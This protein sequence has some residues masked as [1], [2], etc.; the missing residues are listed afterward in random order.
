VG[1]RFAI[2]G[3]AL[4]LMTLGAACGGGSSGSPAPATAGDFVSAFQQAFCEL[5]VRCKEE[6]DQATCM[7]AEPVPTP[8][9]AMLVADVGN[10][11][12]AYDR[13]SAAQCLDDIKTAPCNNS[14]L[15]AITSCGATFVSSVPVGG[16]CSF[17]SD[18]SNGATCQ[19]T[20]CSQACCPGTCAALVPMGGDCSVATIPCVSGTYCRTDAT[21]AHCAAQVTTAG[22]ACD[23]LAACTFPMSCRADATGAM[24]CQKL[25]LTGQSCANFAL[26]ESLLDGCD[27][28]TKICTARGAVGAA[29]TTSDNCLEEAFCDSSTSKCV[30]RGKPGEACSGA[31]SVPCLGLLQCDGTTSTCTARANTGCP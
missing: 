23:A 10:G 14:A 15:F 5:A 8:E 29:C 30:L 16:T 21:G 17:P 2:V 7:A 19:T 18:C 22:A 12:A 28:T 1:V 4:A 26:C 6:P 31:G 11:R 25:P 27:Q 20:S 24:T 9:L 3:G 13:S